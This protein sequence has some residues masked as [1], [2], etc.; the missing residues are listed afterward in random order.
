MSIRRNILLRVYLAFG[1]I[2]VLA[3][4]V[5]VQLYRLQFVQGKKWRAMATK[6]STRYEPIPAARGN[7]L[8]VDGSLLATSVPEYEVHMDMLAGGLRE[9][10]LFYGKV[11]SLALKLS[12]LYPDKS[13]R[14]FSRILRNA[15]KDSARYVLIRRKVTYQELKEIRTFPLLSLGARGG[16][17]LVPQN[18]RILPFKSLAAR[19]IGYK[20]ENDSTAV[21]LEGAY[22]SYINGENGRHLVQRVAGGSWIPVNGDED[23][24]PPKDGADII[25]TINVNYQDLAQRVLKAR[26]DS[27]GADYGCVI[28]MEVATGEIRAIANFTKTTDGDY[29]EELNYAISNAIDPGST[30]KLASYMT[31]FDQHKI[32]TNSLVDANNGRYD[33]Y[34]KGKLLKTFHDAEQGNYVMTAKKAFEESSNV[35]VVKFVSAHYA[36]DPREFTNN[37]RDNLHLNDKL[38]LQI[39]GEAHPLVKDPSARSWSKLTLPQMAYGYEMKIT[40]LQMLTLYNGVANNGQMIAPIF[41]REIQRMGNT[42][43]QFHARVINPKMCSDATLGKV[44]SMLEGV[45][46]EGTGK[47]VIK[48][49][50]YT[51]A[52]KTG[53]AQ[54]ANGSKGYGITKTYQASFCGYFP[55]NH[56]KYSMIVVI[57]NPT[58][59]SYLAALVAGPVFRQIADRIYA[60]DPDLNHNAQSHYIGNITPP[61]AKKGNVHALHQVYSML[62]IKTLYASNSM[63][64]VIDTTN[65]IAAEPNEYKAGTVPSVMGM[66]LSDALYVLG[67]AGYK[68]TARGSGA[69]ITQSVTGGS[70]IPKGSKITIE[71]Q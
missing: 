1:L 67:N 4:A 68:V 51:V 27:T 28:L 45:V 62:N 3:G 60:S 46:T 9:D 6:L 24:T 26:L 41:V 12:Q 61:V 22:A 35:A 14:D 19:T 18:K 59:G 29:K 44:K 42:V 47:N 37:L 38:Q 65:G 21:G 69:V 8:S 49:P 34:Y 36:E 17:V 32:D 63:S 31:M 55:A 25:S 54:I 5:A 30:F 11:D 70:F 2:L 53:T 66:D 56:P 40:P 50:L 58:K 71:L 15:R 13:E 57:N 23:E 16:L 10:K 52:G 33:M 43:E 20:N 7:I 39:P 64:P 48:N